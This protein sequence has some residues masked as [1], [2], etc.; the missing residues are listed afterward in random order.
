MSKTNLHETAWQRLKYQNTDHA[1]IGDATGLRGSSTA[2]NFYVALFSTAPTD[3]TAGT[4]SSYTGY[5][6]QAVARNGS[7]WTELNGNV[8]N[9]NQIDFP[10]NT[11]ASQDANAIGILTALSGGDLLDYGALTGAPRTIG[12]GVTPRVLAGDF[13]NQED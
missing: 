4:E 1:N 8:E 3:S 5:A 13:D 10:E 12:A 6:R 2:G 9:T 7:N 11:G